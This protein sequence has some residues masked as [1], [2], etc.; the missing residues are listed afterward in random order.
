LAEELGK[1]VRESRGLVAKLQDSTR[2]ATTAGAASSAQSIDELKQAIGQLDTTT[3]KHTE[4]LKLLKDVLEEHMKWHR[5][6][7][8]VGAK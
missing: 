8:D 6:H 2:T 1:Q 4:Q 7:S 3:I 5:T